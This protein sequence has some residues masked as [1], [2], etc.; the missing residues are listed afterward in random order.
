MPHFGR[1]L[2]EAIITAKFSAVWIKPKLNFSGNHI[3]VT[4][5]K[6]SFDFHGYSQF[7]KL[8]AHH[9]KRW[10][11]KHVD[12]S[13]TLQEVDFDLL[14]TQS[15]NARKM[16]GPDQYLHNPIPRAELFIDRFNH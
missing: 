6:V 1:R 13:Y 7:D 8:L 3:F 10:L 4:D 12:W 11:Q 14:S 9:K 5:G 15:L 2:S 16:L